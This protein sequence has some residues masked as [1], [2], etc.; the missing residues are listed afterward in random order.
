MTA[1]KAYSRMGFLYLVF[2]LAV[3]VVQLILSYVLYRY[4]PALYD[5][6]SFLMIVSSLSLYGTGLLILPFGA[7]KLVR[8]KTVPEKHSMKFSELLQA[9]CVTY[10]IV[11]VSN[12]VGQLI[13]GLLET[14]LGGAVVNPV[15]D[16]VEN[17][18]PLLLFVLTGLIAPAF[19]EWFF[20]KILVDR[21]LAYGEAAAILASGLMFGLFHG[22]L[23]QF[24]YAF[25]IGSF[26]AYIY[27]R[28]GKLRYVMLLHGMLNVFSSVFL[29]QL[30]ELVNLDA[31]YA[32]AT[33]TMEL[34]R[35][36]L[37]NP[38]EISALAIA[39]GAA[40]CI[41][42][43]G[44]I[45]VIRGRKRF[46][47]KPQAQQ[48]SDGGQMKTALLNA[49]MICYVVYSVIYIIVETVMEMV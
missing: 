28:T 47:L 32:A 34:M 20:R 30:L 35:Y 36:C 38:V 31:F 40:Y 9:F 6:Y 1:K 11:I 21:L 25:A 42:I 48:P 29:S 23:D 43:A 7:G 49:G 46:F 14:F 17:L 3:L 8:E 10:L 2:S 41:M 27:I 4:Y 44:L 12:L 13:I 33:D 18:S 26:F 15:D 19:E 16:L 24:F 45:F 37:E 22:N 39:E 5:S